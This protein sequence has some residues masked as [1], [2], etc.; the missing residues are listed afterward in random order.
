MC[1]RHC[2]SSWR[3]SDSTEHTGT[4]EYKAIHKLLLSSGIHRVCGNAKKV[5][6]VSFKKYLGLKPKDWAAQGGVLESFAP[7]GE[8]G[9]LEV[10]GNK[11]V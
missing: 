9:G 1:T 8:E 7:K 6:E 4:K 5:R 2:P 10:E 11:V 3:K